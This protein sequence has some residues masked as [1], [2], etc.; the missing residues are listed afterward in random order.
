MSAPSNI[1]VGV[2]PR[3]GAEDVRVTLSSYAGHALI[4][5]RTFADLGDA[6]ERRATRKGV[7]L[8][9]ARLPALIAALVEAE[10]EARRRGL[11]DGRGQA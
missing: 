2:I 10:K 6:D 7:S 1:L 8:K 4:D 11:L 3:N 9:L 5:V